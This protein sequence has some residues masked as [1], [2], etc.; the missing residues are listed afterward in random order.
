M[1]NHDAVVTDWQQNAASHDEANYEFLRSLK[2]RSYGFRPDAL[3]AQLHEQA[4][5]IVDCTRCA[6]CC[7]TSDVSVTAEDI[8]RIAG[9]LGMTVEDFI[10]THLKTDEEKGAYTVR[11]KPCSFLGEDDRCTIYDVRPTVCRQYPHTDRTGFATRTML[12]AQNALTC[13]AVFWIVEQMK[14]RAFGRA[15]PPSTR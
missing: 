4:F 11:R 5:R 15:D 1:M 7:K 13:P 2:F 12:H 9:H 10:A 6:N 3:A 14:R 8:A